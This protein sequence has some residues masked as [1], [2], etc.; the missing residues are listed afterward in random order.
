MAE[1]ITIPSDAIIYDID[2]DL[3]ERIQDQM[4][5]AVQYDT[6][7]RYIRATIYKNGELYPITADKIITF[8]ATK[9]D[10]LGIDNQASIDSQGRIIY[11]MTEQTTAKHGTFNAEFRIYDTEV[12]SGITY[13][14][15]KTVFSF[16]VFVAKSSLKDDTVISSN[17]FNV[18]TDLIST[19]GDIISDATTLIANLT[20][21]EQTVS[22]NE[23]IRVENEEERVTNEEGRVERDSVRPVWHYVTQAEY[24]ALPSADKNNPLNIYQITDNTD[25]TLYTTLADLL[26]QITTALNAV[27]SST[28]NINNINDLIVTTIQTWSSSK[29]A[30][31]IRTY[32]YTAS[33]TV[34]SITHNLNYAPTTDDLQI[35]YNGVLLDEGDNFTHSADYKTINLVGWTIASGDKLY[36][37][38]YKFTK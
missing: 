9:P 8:S 6:R 3:H 35:F 32:K 23:D 14:R 21:L 20:E 10:N 19:V 22:S 15:R 33:S 12:I 29:I 7:T 13:S 36:F 4:V 30:S 1:I 17:E 5:S 28:V 26:N 25:A 34:S 31:R 27:Q 11:M 24:D 2:L 16:K 37:K 18:L 38:L